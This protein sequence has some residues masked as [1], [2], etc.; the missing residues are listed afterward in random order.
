MASKVSIETLKSKDKTSYVANAR[1]VYYLICREYRLP[2]TQIGIEVKRHHATV[3]QVART[4]HNYVN[5][6]DYRSSCV[7]HKAKRI[8]KEIEANDHLIEIK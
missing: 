1:G 7:Y 6:N 4:I 2:V 5:V 3:I 8:L